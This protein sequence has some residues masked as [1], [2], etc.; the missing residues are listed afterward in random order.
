MMNPAYKVWKNREERKPA[1]PNSAA[2]PRMNPNALPVVTNMEDYMQINDDLKTTIPMA[3]STEA[4]IEMMQD[5][6]MAMAV[7]MQSDE[8]VDELG[9]ILNKYEVPMGLMNKRTYKHKHQHQHIIADSLDFDFSF[10]L[11][12]SNPLPFICSYMSLIFISFHFIYST[13]L[14]SLPSFFSTTNPQ[15]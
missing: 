4:T 9:G 11:H 12:F 14:Y 10:C 6:E 8:M 1:V 2:N 3:A 15:Y 7:G 13:L 5:G